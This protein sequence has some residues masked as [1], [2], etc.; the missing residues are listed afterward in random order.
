MLWR[1]GNQIHGHG[2]DYVNLVEQLSKE[3][4]MMHIVEGDVFA[5][6]VYRCLISCISF[7]EVSTAS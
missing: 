7:G 3:E 6:N 4:T 2:D 5:I 1:V